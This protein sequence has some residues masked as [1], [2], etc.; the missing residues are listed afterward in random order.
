MSAVGEFR[1]FMSTP[2]GDKDMIVTIKEDGNYFSGTLESDA[3]VYELRDVN[4]DGN[5]FTGS[6]TLST[7]MGEIDATLTCTVDG[8]EVTG[9][10][11]TPFMPIVATG[12]KL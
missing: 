1:I 4:V 8:E 2:I 11:M 12:K 7:P 10:L 6:A 5:T 9:E 3:R